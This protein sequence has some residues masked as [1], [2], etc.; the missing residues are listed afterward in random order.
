[1]IPRT[2]P[3]SLFY[4]I[5]VGVALSGCAKLAPKPQAAAVDEAEAAKPDGDDRKGRRAAA[6]ADPATKPNGRFADPFEGEKVQ[7][8]EKAPDDAPLLAPRGTPLYKLSNARIGNPGPGPYPYLM[9]DYECTTG[10][11]GG[12]PSLVVRYPDGDERTVQLQS[13][14]R[15]PKGDTLKVQIGGGFRPGAQTPKDLEL[16]LVQAD[17]R[18]HEEGFKPRYKVS[19]SVTVGDYKRD[20][21]MA[22][23]WK[24][25][26]VAKLN[27]PPPQGP[28][29]NEDNKSIGQD[30]EFAGN[31][32]A[33]G[34]PV[35]YVDKAQKPVLG[36]AYYLAQGKDAAGKAT[37]HVVHFTP[38]Y[39]PRQPAGP[40]MTKLMAKPGYAVGG[41]AVKSSDKLIHAIQV[42]FMKLKP[43]G[44]LDAKDSYA[45]QWLGSPDAGSTEKKLDG[46]GAKVIGFSEKAFGHLLAIALV[47]PQ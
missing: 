16:F 4:A 27:D 3:R 35:R 24:K 8:A 21:T 18:W 13:F 2:L 12:D 43:D 34:V 47:V 30:L 22:R 15:L 37:K 5:G 32:D 10:K 20:L 31:P 7:P 33:Q 44:S 26:E 19:N 40:I 23:A 6:D 39:H 25:D 42:T 14:G 17:G 9:V 38:V 36:V 46:G 45:S 41:L 28:N 29:P 1:M 11:P